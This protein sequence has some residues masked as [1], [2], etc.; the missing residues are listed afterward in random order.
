MKSVEENI[1]S[2]S[3]A[4]LSEARGEADQVLADAKAKA[5]AARQQASEQAERERREILER[6]K[7]EAE[8]I[9]GQKIAATQ[10]KARTLTLDSREKLLNKVYTTALQEL[11]SVQQ[12]TDYEEIA[13]TL[14]KEAIIQLR[15]S[16]V[17]VRADKRTMDHFSD[18]FLEQLSRE[19]DVKINRGDLLPR[20]I[21][22]IVESSNGHVQYDN[23]LE[24]RLQRMWNAQRAPIYHLLMGEQL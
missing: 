11:L 6:A 15:V 24:T 1:D 10:L 5:D 2:L 19:L 4:I 9:R 8:H 18:K 21:G 16:E 14:L 3:R 17:V 7:Q 22:V 12:W 20:G 13:R 23:T